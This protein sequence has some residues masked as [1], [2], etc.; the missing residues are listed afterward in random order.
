MKKPEKTEVL[1]LEV[2]PA[3]KEHVETEA[4]R[5]NLTIAEHLRKL[6][7]GDQNPIEIEGEKK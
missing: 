5:H 7:F 2:T 6:I 4:K 3:E 1:S